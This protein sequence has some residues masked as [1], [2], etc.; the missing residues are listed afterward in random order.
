MTHNDLVKGRVIPN[1]PYS[2]RKTVSEKDQRRYKAGKRVQN[3]VTTP[4]PPEATGLKLGFALHFSPQ[5]QLIVIEALQFAAA[6]NQLYG[7]NAAI[8]PAGTGV[9]ASWRGRSE[10]AVG[11]AWVLVA[12]TTRVAS[13][14]R[15]EVGAM[16]FESNLAGLLLPVAMDCFYAALLS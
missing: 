2:A 7:L 4:S 9:I 11:T 16:A 15:E 10:E 12:N 8:S 6:A 13:R 5:L 1:V 3:C 14:A